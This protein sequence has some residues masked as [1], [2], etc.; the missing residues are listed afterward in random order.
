[1]AQAI[2]AQVCVAMVQALLLVGMLHTVH[3]LLVSNIY[4]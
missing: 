4:I 2:A 1:M 3:V